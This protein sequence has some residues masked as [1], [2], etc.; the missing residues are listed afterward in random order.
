[1]HGQYDWT[2]DPA[3]DSHRYEWDI[4]CTGDDWRHSH[5]FEHHTFTNI[6][7]KD[8]DV[9]YACC[10]SAPSS[11][12]AR[13]TWRSRL[14][15]LVL[16]LAVPV[17]RRRCTTCASTSCS[18]ASSR[19]AQFLRRAR[20]FATQGGAGS[21]ART[22][23]SIPRSRWATRRAS[24]PATSSPTSCAT[25]GRSRSSSAATS[26][27]VCRCLREEETPDESR[28]QW[29]LRQLQRLGQHR[30]RA[31]V[32]PHDRPP[33]PP[34]RAPPVPRSAGGAL[35]G[36]G[37]ARARD[38]RALR[39]GRTAPAASRRQLGSVARR[40]L[41]LALPTAAAANPNGQLDENCAAPAAA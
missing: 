6:L 33:Q 15:A 36:D 10:A 20:P 16:A 41:R 26:P 1:M 9:G 3:L 34:D 23:S 24:S 11:R 22:T 7:G 27:T 8:R 31:L 37:A 32:P 2:R 18:T 30:G 4:V 29:Y 39:A 12:G 19:S 38:L 21:S 25:C 14:V 13:R 5:N 28:G 40:L 17:G 35:S